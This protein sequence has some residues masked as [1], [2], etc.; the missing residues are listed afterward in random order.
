MMIFTTVLQGFVCPIQPQLDE[1]GD[2]FLR[3]GQGREGMQLSYHTF[4]RPWE[5][6]D[7]TFNICYFRG[8]HIPMRLQYITKISDPLTS[9]V[10]FRCVNC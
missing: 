9:S 1:S 6:S 7:V 10:T 5:R 3:L 4:F 8:I 2:S